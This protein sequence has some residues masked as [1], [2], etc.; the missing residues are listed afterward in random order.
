LKK[1]DLQKWQSAAIIDKSVRKTLTQRWHRP[2]RC[3]V[4]T[5]IAGRP[6]GV[7]VVE[8]LAKTRDY[9]LYRQMHEDFPCGP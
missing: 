7:G 4:Q 1:R 9:V 2:F 3:A 8:G 5:I 6:D